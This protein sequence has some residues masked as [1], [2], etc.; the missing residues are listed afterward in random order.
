MRLLGLDL[1]TTGLDW[2][3][4]ARVIELGVALAEAGSPYP[5]DAWGRYC[6]DENVGP[7]TEKI[8]SLTGIRDEVLR[9]FG[10]HPTTV[11]QELDAYCSDR[12][13]DYIVAHN[14]DNFDHPFLLSE[15]DKFNIAAPTL[16]KLPWID[17]RKDIPF[18]SE[19]VS[20]KLQHLLSDLHRAH[21]LIAH[22]AM[23]DSAAALWL[24]S[25]YDFNEVLEYWKIPWIVIRAD[26]PHPR[27]DNGEGKDKAKAAQYRWQEINH[28]IYE[29][30]WVK[31]IKKTELEAEKKRLPEYP[32][33]V[34]E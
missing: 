2:K 17:T 28:K 1:E 20:R 21:N 10:I 31:L 13:V 5:L 15:L 23:F 8:T 30:C 22:R 4:G 33:L 19:P 16:R 18:K 11:Y 12:R 9:E 29:N 32:I 26:V 7:L 25:Q 14:G 6:Y 24:L 34:I 27:K 3:N